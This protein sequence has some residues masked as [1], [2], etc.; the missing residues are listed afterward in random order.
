MQPIAAALV[1]YLLERRILAQ[2]GINL[3]G[4]E[5]FDELQHLGLRD[6]HVL[7]PIP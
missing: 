3:R 5:A 7:S 4:T 1:A 2:R 6:G